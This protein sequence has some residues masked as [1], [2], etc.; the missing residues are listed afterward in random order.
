MGG[1]GVGVFDRGINVD[2][3]DFDIFGDLWGREVVLLV[4]VYFDKGGKRLGEVFGGD[5]G[6]GFDF[7]ELFGYY[8]VFGG[9]FLGDGNEGVGVGFD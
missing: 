2:I 4:V 6:E 3:R 1:R 8:V 5:G 7:E 9:V